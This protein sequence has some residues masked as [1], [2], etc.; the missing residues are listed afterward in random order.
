MVTHT[1]PTKI[2]H[3]ATSHSLFYP[4]TQPELIRHF[5]HTYP[6]TQL[7]PRNFIYS[8]SVQLFVCQT[9]NKNN[10]Y[11]QKFVKFK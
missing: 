6:A 8:L 2:N 3:P 9:K 7:F 5:F 10:K 4:S 1:C 11:K